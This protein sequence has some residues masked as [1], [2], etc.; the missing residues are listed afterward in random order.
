VSTS[1]RILALS[2]PFG[3]LADLATRTARCEVVA[4]LDACLE[5]LGAGGSAVEATRPTSRDGPDVSL[6]AV[7]ATWHRPLSVVRHLRAAGHDVPIAL[8]VAAEDVEATRTTLALLPGAGEVAVVTAGGG[9]GDDDLVHR[10]EQLARSSRGRQQLR[11]AL[12]VMNRALAGR[13]QPTAQRGRSGISEHYLAAL[14]RHAAD[15]IVALDG[16]SRIVTLNA[17]AERTLGLPVDE[18]EGRTLGDLLGDD[19]PGELTTLLADASSGVDQVHHELPVHLRD[20]HRALLSAT[21]AAVRDDTGALAGLV[22]IARD[23]TAERRSEQQLRELQKAESLATLASGV[24][25]DFNNLLVQIQGWTDLARGTPDDHRLVAEALDNI[26]VATRQA[27]ELSRAMLVYGGRGSF[28][29][30]RL[31]L[32]SL[33]TELRPLLVASVPAKIDLELDTATPAEVSGDP[34]QLRQVVLNLVVN[35]TEAIGDRRGTV[36]VRTRS[37]VIRTG[38]GL[39]PAGSDEAAPPAPLAGGAYGIIEV[40]DTGPGLDPEHHHRLFD[41]FFTTKFTG[42]GLGLAASQGIAR[43]HGGVI[44][45][46]AAPGGGARFRIHLPVTRPLPAG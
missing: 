2:P 7:D 5:R 33:V 34:T 9:E 15:T 10:L 36:V 19:D 43:A 20:G 28:E 41:P 4:D 24:A 11:G 21:A 14:V 8:V 44:T 46:D 3:G 12:D 39:G 25:H 37:E 29:P 35:A 27:A 45:A 32:A 40:E 13:S 22:L 30:Q 42:R 23:V 18:V 31:E 38:P 1:H 17:A 6:V 16:R 26:A